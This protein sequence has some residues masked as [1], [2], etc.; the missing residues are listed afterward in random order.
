MRGEQSASVPYILFPAW[1]LV[2]NIPIL[3]L[4]SSQSGGVTTFVPVDKEEQTVL[5][6]L[7]KGNPWRNLETET[8]PSCERCWEFVSSSPSV[9]LPGDR[10]CFGEAVGLVCVTSVTELEAAL[11]L[12]SLEKDCS[13][14]FSLG[15]ALF[16]ARFGKQNSG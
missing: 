5:V 10:H 6:S 1:C 7:F 9:V 3:H 14:G 16:S 15:S 4:L 11:V 2:S 13:Q 8:D 12:Y